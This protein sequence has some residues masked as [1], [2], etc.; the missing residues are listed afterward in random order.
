M[1]KVKIVKGNFHSTSF[2]CFEWSAYVYLFFAHNVFRELLS[3]I[4]K[5]LVQLQQMQCIINT[6]NRVQHICGIFLTPSRGWF[7]ICCYNV[8]IVFS[9]PKLGF[10]VNEKS[11]SVTSFVINQ[12]NTINNFNR[13]WHNELYADRASCLHI[14]QQRQ[15][16]RTHHGMLMRFTS[17]YI[18]SS[19]YYSRSVVYH[20]LCIMYIKWVFAG[21][22]FAAVVVQGATKVEKAVAKLSNQVSKVTRHGNRDVNAA[23]ECLEH[24]L[25]TITSDGVL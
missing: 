3:T 7:V 4:S 9:F 17:K 20:L 14:Y 15:H 25:E 6:E 22:L 18:V 13:I 1:R 24:C 16:V 23:I 5:S 19:L 8:I 12:C 2:K 10:S 11:H 21:I